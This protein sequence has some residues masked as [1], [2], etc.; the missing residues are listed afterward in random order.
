[1]ERGGKW[2]G[3]LRPG[4]ARRFIGQNIVKCPLANTP[5]GHEDS[6]LEASSPG[7]LGTLKKAIMDEG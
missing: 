2:L 6:L 4:K 5:Y 3:S 7:T 1:M